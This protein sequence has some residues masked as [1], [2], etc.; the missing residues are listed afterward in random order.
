[1]AIDPFMEVLLTYMEG[2]AIRSELKD[3]NRRWLLS[4]KDRKYL[5]HGRCVLS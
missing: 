3:M 1:M 5:E 4:L 2:V